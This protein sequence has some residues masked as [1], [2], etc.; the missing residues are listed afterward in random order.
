MGRGAFWIKQTS[1]F[2]EVTLQSGMQNVL[3]VNVIVPGKCIFL[4]RS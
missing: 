2:K 1:G 4:M 3:S